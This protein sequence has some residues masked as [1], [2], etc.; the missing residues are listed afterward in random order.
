MIKPTQR[1]LPFQV[2]R[3]EIFHHPKAFSKVASL[4][5]I[6][7]AFL[8]SFFY[9]IELVLYILLFNFPLRESVE[10]VICRLFQNLYIG[11]WACLE[12]HVLHQF[13]F[14]LMFIG[15]RCP[16]T[17]VR[18]PFGIGQ[19]LVHL[20]GQPGLLP[21]ETLE[22]RRLMI[23]NLDGALREELTVGSVIMRPIK[24]ILISLILVLV[25]KRAVYVYV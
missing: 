25:L 24:L 4:H 20:P 22:T 19:R 5:H 21:H 18:N 12:V 17:I 9:F 10:I 14:T 23:L 15:M 7:A 2:I 1:W 6:L 11:C 13:T 3:P 8:F 16:R